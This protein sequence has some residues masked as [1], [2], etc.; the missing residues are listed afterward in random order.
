MYRPIPSLWPFFVILIPNWVASSSSPFFFTF[1][2][3]VSTFERV[4]SFKWDKSFFSYVLVSLIVL[5]IQVL[6]FKEFIWHKL[7]QPTD[8]ERIEKKN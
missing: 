3:L 6:G 4:K 8:I 2:I 1:P 7:N 5:K